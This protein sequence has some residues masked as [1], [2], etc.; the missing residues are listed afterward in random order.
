MTEPDLLSAATALSSFAGTALTTRIA[1][2]EGS[3]K[4]ATAESVHARI[5]SA[6]VSHE[7]LASAHVLKRVAG[8]I[9]VV[10][11]TIGIL[12]CL[13]H[14]LE[15]GEQILSLSL[16]AGNTGRQ[17]DLETDVQIGEFK[18]IHWQGGAETIRQ[19]SLFKD[20]FQM[21]EH[22]TTK[23]KVMY[24]L[25]TEY[26]LR[27]LTSGRALN[28]V[29][30]RNRSLWEQFVTKYGERYR[31]VGEYYAVKGAEVS[32]VDVSPY[33]PELNVVTRRDF[34]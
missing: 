3:F 25:G 23:R 5:D 15:S 33:V 6:A 4:G 21:A 32:L 13:P 17:F 14:I 12:L 19:N 20:L 26:P 2:L 7:L 9:N 1:S 34:E 24:V 28:S 10:I 16:G 8:Q 27:F 30:S 18:F 31:T 11:H 22:S 29:M